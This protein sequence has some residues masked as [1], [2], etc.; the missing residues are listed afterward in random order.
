VWA[1]SRALC[2]I[3]EYTRAVTRALPMVLS[4]REKPTF[5][6]PE[7]AD[8][9]GLVA[10]GGVVAPEWLLAAYARGIFPWYDQGL[11]PL[12]WSPNPRAILDG[13]RLH[14][15]RSM[16][17]VL[18]QARFRVSFDTAF[19]AVMRA[20]GDER[21]E[22]T[23]IL[24]EMISAYV[25]LHRRGHA[26]S[27]EVWD[28]E[29]L[30]GGLYGVQLGGFFAAESMFHRSTNASKVALICAVRSL[31]GAGVGLFDVQ[32]LTPHLSSLGAHVIPRSAYLSRLEQA[33]QLPV[34]LEGL[35]PSDR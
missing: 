35:H 11:P 31:F 4:A 18:R 1:E 28:G 9:R 6:D 20:C 33:R 22:G 16:E 32:F 14:V 17:R 19:E 15:S 12:W 26:H 5:P 8:D 29:R 25:E 27:F 2:E 24:P 34:S 23:W 3:E 13:E 10:V 7:Q 21:D 30:V